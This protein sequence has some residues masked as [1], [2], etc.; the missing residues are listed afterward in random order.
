MS[1]PLG[2]T[3]FLGRTLRHVRLVRT[4][5]DGMRV[6]RAME[7]ELRDRL[8]A[9]TGASMELEFPFRDLGVAE[10]FERNIFSILFLSLF[11]WL[12]IPEPRVLGYGLI[13][14]ALRGVV[15]A[16]DNILDD[17]S[18]GALR[19]R[20][21]RGHVLPNVMLLLLQS[22][23]LFEVLGELVPDPASRVRVQGR[24]IS[25]LQAI[26]HEEGEEEQV[27][28]GVLDP[29]E[30]LDRIHR[31]RGGQLL[32]LAFVAPVALEMDRAGDLRVASSSV[33]RIGLGLQ[34]LDDI[35]DLALDV[36]ARNHN[37][38]RSWIV[39]RGP[40]GPCMDGA[41]RGLPFADLERPW[42]TFPGATQAVLERATAEARAGFAALGRL[43]YPVGREDIDEL[44]GW[45]FRA[46][47]LSELWTLAR[48]AQGV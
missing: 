43:G 35:T 27:V 17:E 22:G 44:L 10:Y 6:H 16:T 38:L 25:A 12:G 21:G 11:R 5:E 24:I 4:L 23:L 37:I 33:H 7:A 45:L 2:K 30:L 13:L 41:L 34:I 31:Y 3:T 8:L 40:D 19:I 46:R 18:K 1:V 28:E 9:V 42:K 39:C 29:D 47:G 20:G 32:E 26:A 14:H 36:Q 15:T 48:P